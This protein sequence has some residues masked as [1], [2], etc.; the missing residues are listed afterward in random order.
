M[1][2]AVPADD[3]TATRIAAAAARI[4]RR[5]QIPDRETESFSLTAV[6]SRE[7]ADRMFDHASAGGSMDFGSSAA[8]ARIR[9]RLSTSA[10]HNAQVMTCSSTG[11]RA[12]SVR[13]PVT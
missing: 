6:S 2:K 3:K 12:S 5:C 1:Y 13:S 4:Y 10:L 11:G 7:I 8:Q 9:F